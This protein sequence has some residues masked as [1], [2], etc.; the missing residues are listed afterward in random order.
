MSWN[1]FHVHASGHTLEVSLRNRDRGVGLE[2]IRVADGIREA[3]KAT[4]L[5]TVG[6]YAC[7]DDV[8]S[9]Q[10]RR[11]VDAATLIPM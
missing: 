5:S 11:R 8:A 2:A 1:P 10:A 6:E 7:G 3:L 4:R 9:D